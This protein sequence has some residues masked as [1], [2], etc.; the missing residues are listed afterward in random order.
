MNKILSIFFLALV[1]ASCQFFDRQVPSEEELLKERLQEIDW[2]Q[3]TEYPSV[4]ECD[5][6]LDK[7]GKKQCFFQYLTK[8]IQ[9]KLNDDSLNQLYPEIDTIQVRVTVFPDSKTI[10]EPQFSTTE[11]AHY[12]KEKID[13]I[14][15]SR[16]H[17]FPK[18]QPAQ[19]EGIPVKTEFILPVILKMER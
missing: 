19:K 7:E 15:Q 8:I 13:S 14:I 11:N 18:I 6:I 9:Q 4:A 10:F 17:D 1:L 2:K 3:V 5:S 12:S 16:L